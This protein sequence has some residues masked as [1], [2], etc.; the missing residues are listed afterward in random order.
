MLPTQ[1]VQWN[2]LTNWL[3]DQEFINLFKL[4]VVF[5]FKKASFCRH[6]IPLHKKH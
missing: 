3:P 2:T 6:D 4:T 5:Y 1:G